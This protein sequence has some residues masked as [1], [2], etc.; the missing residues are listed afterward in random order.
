MG[1]TLISPDELLPH[2]TIFAENLETI[3]LIHGAC[4]D[5]D[6]WNLVTPHLRHGYHILL[7]DLPRHG[8]AQIWKPFSL[9]HAADL[10][11][12]L[13]DTQALGGR[14]HVVG[15]SLGASVALCLAAKY[16]QFVK[17]MV[18][19]GF[20]KL[21]R[22]ALTPYLPYLIWVTQRIENA[23]PR[24]LMRWATDG[25]DIQKADL[26][27][28][29]VALTR[30]IFVNSLSPEEWPAAWPARTLVI[31]ATKGGLVPTN[32]NEESARKV[33][34]IGHG[35]NSETRGV[36]HPKMRHPWNRQDPVLFAEVVRAWIRKEDL[37]EGF[38]AL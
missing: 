24:S 29:D 16:P 20:C 23:V 11:A 25:C 8:A 28:V 35:L 3:L 9:D 18:I 6:D 22:S 19:S 32:D 27:K 34:K 1:T 7:P 12:K 13:I 26:S 5:R 33:Y 31:A 36:K 4:V 38:E 37:P 15:H 14:A 21:P 2:S 30:E 17:S 10:L